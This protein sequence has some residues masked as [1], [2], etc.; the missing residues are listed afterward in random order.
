MGKQLTRCEHESHDQSQ[1]LKDLTSRSGQKGKATETGSRKT[2]QDAVSIVEA[3]GN[4]VQKQGNGNETGTEV[5]TTK[6]TA[7]YQNDLLAVE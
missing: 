3:K 1:A 6:D 7:Y 4:E 5:R 2:S